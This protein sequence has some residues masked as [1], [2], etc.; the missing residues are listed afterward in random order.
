MEDG[1]GLKISSS[2]IQHF[3]FAKAYNEAFPLYMSIGMT[4]R[5]YWDDDAMLTKQ[6]REAFKLT[7]SRKNRDAWLQGRYVYEAMSSALSALFAKNKSEIYQ[8][9]SEPY[10][11]TKEEIEE[12]ERKEYEARRDRIMASFIGSNAKIHEG[13]QTDE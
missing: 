11:M 3:S 7:Q 10:P 6:Y 9:P 12:R 1:I 2:E 13:G 5:E 8:Y 4:P